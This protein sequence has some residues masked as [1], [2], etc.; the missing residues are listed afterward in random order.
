MSG[1][2]DELVDLVMNENVSAIQILVDRLDITS[3]EAIEL[4]NELLG[5]NRL[6]G[7]LTEDGTRFFKTDVKLSKAPTIERD[8]DPPDFTSF[9]SRPRIVITIIG[10]IIVAAG[11][12]V[13]SFST[14]AVEQNFAAILILAG[15][16]V[17]FT[18]LYLISKRKTPA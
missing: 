6:N 16:F 15:I 7:T 11:V 5:E 18:G 17:A 4:I 9:N 1:K 2:K 10:F 8:D 3:D 13:N 14:D 12:I